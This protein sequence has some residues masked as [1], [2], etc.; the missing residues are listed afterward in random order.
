MW[1]HLSARKVRGVIA[2]AVAASFFGIT[3][4]TSVGPSTSAPSAP[5]VGSVTTDQ[6]TPVPSSDGN[7]WG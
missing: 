7:P 5:S 1:S 6:P 2:A 3:A 4:A